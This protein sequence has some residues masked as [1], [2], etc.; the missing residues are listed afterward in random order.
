M[1]HPKMTSQKPKP[2]SATLQNF[3]SETY[4]PRRTPSTSKPPTFTFLIFRA[5]NDFFRAP[6]SMGEP[7]SGRPD[8][9]PQTSRGVIWHVTDP[10]RPPPLTYIAISMMGSDPRSESWFCGIC[11]VDDHGTALVSGGARGSSETPHADAR[12]HHRARHRFVR[13]SRRLRRPGR[14]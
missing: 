11:R 3:S 8:T 5:S 7:Y 4:L 14:R 9:S 10:G 13:R 1:S 6:R 12:D 2:G